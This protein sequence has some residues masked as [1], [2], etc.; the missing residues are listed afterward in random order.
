M[1]D[2]FIYQVV[3]SS[4][5]NNPIEEKNEISNGLELIEEIDESVNLLT[6]KKKRFPKIKIDTSVNNIDTFYGIKNEKTIPIRK[7]KLTTGKKIPTEILINPNP[8][9]ININNWQII[10]LL[11]TIILL[12]ISKAFSST[13]FKQSIKALMKYSIAQEI[14]REEKVFFHRANL[15]F[16]LIHLLA[17]GLLIF[18]LIETFRFQYLEMN[19]FMFFL[20]IIGGLIGT[21]IIKYLTSKILFFILNDTSIASEY[22]FNVSLYN[23]LFGVLL[24]PM[25]I[26]I[27]F[28]SIDSAS[29]FIYAVLPLSV[30]VFLL[31]LVRLFFIGKGKGISYFYIFLY[32]CTLEILPLVV[33]YR[34][35][36]F[37]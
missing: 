9:V 29:I 4:S 34:I 36:I 23:N 16:S 6:K 8:L 28:S 10:T 7:I 24:I 11:I 15:L 30:F 17:A 5:L 31:R 26:I 3:D 14:N 37:K 19:H 18:H 35:F 12:G 32:I 1:A 33:L 20:L 13:R 27:Y 21:Y 2:F 22:I 25:L